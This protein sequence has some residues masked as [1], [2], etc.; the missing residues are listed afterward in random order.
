MSYRLVD[1]NS[2]QIEYPKVNELPCIIVDLPKG[3]DNAYHFLDSEPVKHGR[4][5]KTGQSFIF[6]K[7]FRNYFCS[8]C[9]FELDKSIRTEYRYC[10][11]CGSRM[12][13]V[14]E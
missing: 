12:D 14:E 5:L 7:K 9:F 2:I 4:W 3:L 8:E 6:P 1:A 11:N 13:E 10:P